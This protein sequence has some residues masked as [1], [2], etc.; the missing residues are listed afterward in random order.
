MS[1]P[2]SFYWFDYE[3]FGTHPAWDRPCQFAGIRTNADFEPIGEPLM[4]YC[5]QSMD[6]LPNPEAC[7]VTG[8]SPEDVNR[9]G[10]SEYDFIRRIVEQLG[11][12]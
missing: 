11:F 10:V 7:R 5:R 4:L 3:T 6:Y 12:Q 2:S 9:Q 8:L 1:Q